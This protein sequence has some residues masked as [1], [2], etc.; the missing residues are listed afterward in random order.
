MRPGM[1]TPRIAAALLALSVPVWAQQA[2]PATT[3]SPEPAADAGKP[4]TI[5][6]IIEQELQPDPTGY[7]YNPQGRRDPFV[8]LLKPV[9]ADQGARTRRPGMEGFLI[10]EVALKGIVRTPKG[11][12]AMLLGTDGKSYFVNVGQRLFDG[13][14]TSIDATTVTFRQEVSDPLSTVKSRDVKKTLYPSEEARQ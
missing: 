11:Y 14:I 13:V 5:K 2:P 9:S 3:A 1:R 8:S 12:T 4:D 10:Q 7:S 6:S